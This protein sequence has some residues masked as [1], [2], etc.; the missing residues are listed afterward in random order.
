M[1][2]TGTNCISCTHP[3]LRPHSKLP[4]IPNIAQPP[5][6]YK[7][8]SCQN[9]SI[10]N[11]ISGVKKKKI[12]SGKSTC[13]MC[14]C[15][16]FAGCI[17]GLFFFPII[18]FGGWHLS[19]LPVASSPV[20]HALGC[21]FP[22]LYFVVLKGAPFTDCTF[23]PSSLTLH[24]STPPSGGTRPPGSTFSTRFPTISL[25]QFQKYNGYRSFTSQ[26]DR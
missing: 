15:M 21:P 24:R 2:F 6:F 12:A 19:R 22:V 7:S 25:F 5:L 20:P 26:P 1:G 9:N 4:N 16:C 23:T 14:Q 11:P 17:F 8:V 18:F 13:N 3:F 10:K